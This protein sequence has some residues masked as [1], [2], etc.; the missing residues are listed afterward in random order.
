M[1]QMAKLLI[2]HVAEVKGGGAFI[3]AAEEG[4][5]EMVRLLLAQRADINELGIEHPTDERFREDVGTALQRAAFEGYVDV[6]RCLIEKG[7]DKGFRGLMGEDNGRVG[8]G[9]GTQRDCIVAFL[10]QAGGTADAVPL[11]PA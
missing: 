7:A 8:E 3:M 1:L 9:K 11:C 6:V 2:D 5:L 10:R 4:N